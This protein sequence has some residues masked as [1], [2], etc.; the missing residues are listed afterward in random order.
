MSDT[1]SSVRQA[2]RV[3]DALQDHEELGITEIAQAL[4]CATSTAHRLAATLL[5]ATYVMKSPGGR[6][7]RLGPAMSGTRNAAAVAHCVDVALPHMEALRNLTGETIQLA[8]LQNISIKFVA[9]VESEQIMRV[10]S[11]I[12]G[13]MPA[14]ATAAGKVLLSY[15][16]ET[17][18][19]ARYGDGLPP[20]ITQFGI[21]SLEELEIQL[22]LARVNGFSQNL[23]EMELGVAALA[24]PVIRPTGQVLCALTL[25]GPL[26]R[27]DPKRLG[28]ESSHESKLRQQLQHQ[29]HLIS[30][31]LTV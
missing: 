23:A 5:E 22:R 21:S 16:S 9:A 4:D 24:V 20:P 15:L 29:A 8:V 26:S 6:K 17:E 11:R 12:G 30:A 14:H 27:F 10:T 28:V 2:L 3:L 18:L 7:Y 19:A 13:L 31:Q 25:S 1:L